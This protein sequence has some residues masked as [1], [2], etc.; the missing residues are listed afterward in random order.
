MKHI[1]QRSHFLA[2]VKGRDA[3]CSHCT[4]QPVRS[5][6]AMSLVQSSGGIIFTPNPD[7]DHPGHFKT[8]LQMV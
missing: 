5:E 1:D 3:A 2:F 8:F 7:P 4:H 6:K